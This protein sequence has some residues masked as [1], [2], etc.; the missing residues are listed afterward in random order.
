VI[1]DAAGNLYG[2]TNTGGRMDRC[3]GQGCGVVFKITP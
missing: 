2:T 3:G 1:L